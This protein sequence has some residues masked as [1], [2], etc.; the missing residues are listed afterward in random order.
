M[1]EILFRGKRVDNGEWVE[2][3]LVNNIFC[4]VDTGAAVPYIINPDDYEEYDCM[5]DI[6]EVILETVGQFTG[7]LDKNGVKIFEGD[8]YTT[9]GGNVYEIRFVNGSFCGGVFD[10]DDSMFSPLGWESPDDDEDLYI[11]DEFF[12]TMEVIGNIHDQ[13][14]K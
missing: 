6:G 9:F 13:K 2:G 14:E 3:S 8:L 7:L 4:R 11:D 1:R 10:G 5:E 12:K